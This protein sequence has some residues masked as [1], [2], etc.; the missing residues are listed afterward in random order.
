M[1]A[2]DQTLI[3]IADTHIQPHPDDRLDGE[4]TFANLNAVLDRIASSGI[5]PDGFIFAGDL[6]N[7]GEPASYKRFAVAV[8]KIQNTYGVPVALALGNHDAR[9]PFRTAL[10]THPPSTERH[11]EV[12]TVGPL[13]IIILDTLVPGRAYGQ[14]GHDQL[15][16][17]SVQLGIRAES[18]TILVMHHPPTHGG[19]E[20][21]NHILLRDTADFHE[22]IYGTD[23]IGI[24]AGHVHHP[25]AGMFAGVPVWS[26]PAV[27]Y[28]LDPCWPGETFRS[29][30]GSGFSII[31]IRRRT[32]VASAVM[33]PGMQREI[34]VSPITAS[35]LERWL[36]PPPV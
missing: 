28:S 25:T 2:P 21:L 27:A 23:V 10:L 14:L 18:G 9:E 20:A 22:T 31:H 11:N 29:I 34:A 36:Q 33:M 12:V 24:L 1:A 15:H 13:R 16:W 3:L 4:D 7:D 35:L 5:V 19:V 6:A 8:S 30:T 26:G 17:L 32:M